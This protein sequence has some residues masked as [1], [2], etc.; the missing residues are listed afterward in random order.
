MRKLR[1]LNREEVQDEKYGDE[2]TKFD[3]DESTGVNG[4]DVTDT[5]G[6][7]QGEQPPPLKMVESQVRRSTREHSL[8][9]RYPTSEYIMITKEGE[10]KSF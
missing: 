1:S 6:V 2:P 7:E 9:T 3:A 8:S 10:P 4:D 5:N